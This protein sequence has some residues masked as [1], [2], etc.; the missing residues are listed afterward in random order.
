ME[1]DILIYSIAFGGVAFEPL[2][3]PSM[4]WCKEQAESNESLFRYP[5]ACLTGFHV[6]AIA[7]EG[8]DATDLA[9]AARDAGLTI[10]RGCKG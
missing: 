8:R 9:Q 4:Q 6:D 2:T 7:C 3:L 10:A 1:T 5:D